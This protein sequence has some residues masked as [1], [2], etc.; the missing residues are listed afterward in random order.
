MLSRISSLLS[1]FDREPC[2]LTSGG[3]SLLDHESPCCIFTIEFEIRYR[4][5]FP[6][7][8]H[9]HDPDISCHRCTLPRSI[10]E[11]QCLMPHTLVCDRA[12][13]SIT[14]VT[15]KQEYLRGSLSLFSL[16]YICVRARVCW[17]ALMQRRCTTRE[18]LYALDSQVSG[19][20]RRVPSRRVA[21]P[22]VASLRLATRHSSPMSPRLDLSRPSICEGWPL[23]ESRVTYLPTHLPIYL[24][25]Y[26]SAALTGRRAYQRTV[27][28]VFRFI[29]LRE[30]LVR[31]PPRTPR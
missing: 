7:A 20:S 24:S 6:D 25:I 8:R 17:C 18:K 27:P 23:V 26:P 13:Q 19:L 14:W 31:E 22:R 16:V 15:Y 4:P 11:F 3:K 10:S 2:L 30:R 9:I 28:F 12:R 29:S 1:R 5:R 21:S